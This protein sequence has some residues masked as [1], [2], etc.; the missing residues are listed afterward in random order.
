MT[1]KSD[2]NWV[3]HS[4]KAFME[5]IGDFI[6]QQRLQQ[7]KSQQQLAKEAGIARS[8]L[9]L[10]EKGEN[11]QLLVFVQLLRA[12][13]LLHL[14]QVFQVTQQISPIQLA[15]IEKSERIRARSKNKNESK[16]KSE[17]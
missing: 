10:V 8:T 3:A 13:K 1:D 9:A 15:K 16:P 14:L 4:D 6:R 2:N 17:W 7:N 5:I 11:T 12:L